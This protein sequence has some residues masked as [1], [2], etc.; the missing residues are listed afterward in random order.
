MR[1]ERSGQ[2]IY[3]I[4]H[5]VYQIELFLRMLK[6]HD[7]A[8]VVD[9]RSRPYSS[10]NPQFSKRELSSAINSIGIQYEF[11][12]KALGGLG[13]VSVKSS[14]FTDAM[15]RVLSLQDHGHVAMMCAEKNPAACH[16]ASKL[17]AW[18]HTQPHLG[19]VLTAHITPTGVTDGRQFESLQP[20]GWSELE[21][22]SEQLE[23]G[24][25]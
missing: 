5:S 17:T 8:V 9:V 14:E 3:T 10:H 23:L 7:V 24:L 21:S 16:R 25:T 12:G 6:A 1:R 18:I 19:E 22:R 11:E 4:G 20:H 2:M 15:E 13:D